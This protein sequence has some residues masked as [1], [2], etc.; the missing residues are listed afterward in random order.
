MN[1]RK[2]QNSILVLATLG[3]Y[4]GLVLAGATPQTLAQA[5][6]TRQFDVKDEVEIKDE[7]DKKPDHL[8]A[9]VAESA[10][11]EIDQKLARSVGVFL[12]KFKNIDSI[13]SLN[14]SSD[15]RVE[16]VN[17][18]QS[19]NPATKTYDIS[20]QPPLRQI[21]TITNLP[22]AGIDPLLASDGK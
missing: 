19:I 7:L 18:Q 8:L 4:L 11:T 10:S 17:W 1:N 9:D 12:A 2:N 15:I 5:A 21:L 14:I 16:N 22:R 20:A 3:V 13:G 6:M